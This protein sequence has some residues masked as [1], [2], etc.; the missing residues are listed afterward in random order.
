MGEGGDYLSRAG[1]FTFSTWLDH[2]AGGQRGHGA[3][4]PEQLPPWDHLEVGSEMPYWSSATGVHL[5]WASPALDHD[6]VY[7]WF[8]ECHEVYRSPAFSGQGQGQGQ[9][10]TDPRCGQ[11]GEMTSVRCG[12][13][14]GHL[15]AS[16][17]TGAQPRPTLCE[18]HGGPREERDTFEWMKIRRNNLQNRKSGLTNSASASRISFSTKQLTELEKEFHFN[19]YLSRSR[20]AEIA[21]VL[22]LKENQVKIWF[23]NR[24]MKQKKRERAREATLSSNWDSSEL[25][26]SPVSS[27]PASPQVQVCQQH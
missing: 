15:H 9:Q 17:R 7:S 4:N 6:E 2:S 11:V 16:R 12:T 5:T 8:P 13:S 18:T 26:R 10:S 1:V 21:R 20:R 27:P 24:R 19:K 3:G 25:N 14:H 23:Q 22:H